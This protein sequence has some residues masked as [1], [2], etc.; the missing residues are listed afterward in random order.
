MV[1]I[2]ILKLSVFSNADWAGS[3]YNIRFTFRYCLHWW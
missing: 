2:A 1:T 3:P